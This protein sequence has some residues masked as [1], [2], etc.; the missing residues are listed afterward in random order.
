M[1]Y[2]NIDLSS[3]QID[4]S[5]CNKSI[6]EELWCNEC[7]KH[8]MIGGWT[9]GNLCIDKFIKDSMYNA[10]NVKESKKFLEWVPFDRFKNMKQIGE[11]GFSK[12]YSAT[13]IDGKSKFVEQAYGSWK[14]LDSKPITV[15]LKRL[16]GSQNMS[17]GYLNE[18]Y[19]ITIHNI[20]YLLFN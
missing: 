4:C 18:V 19:F 12:V 10:T 5:F 7:D 20:F 17:E 13:W 3:M 8:K 15:A 11:G 16:N 9:S 6:A 1:C 14:K 2:F